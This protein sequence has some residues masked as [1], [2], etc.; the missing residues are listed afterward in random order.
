MG[1]SAPMSF[2]RIHCP[3]HFAQELLN[4]TE[5]FAKVRLN[6]YK[7][8][9]GNPTSTVVTG[10][11]PGGGTTDVLSVTTTYDARERPSSM[12][13]VLTIGGNEKARNTTTY[14]YDA[15]GRQSS[16]SSGPTSTAD[17]LESQYGY[18]LQQWMSSISTVLG[19]RT[20]FSETLGYDSPST[21][22]GGP[23]YTGLI[24]RKGE[25]W[26][27]PTSSIDSLS[28]SRTED[29]VYDYAA[30]LSTWDDS[31]NGENIS[32]DA[33]GNITLR[34]P[35]YGSGGTITQT[36][37]GDRLATRKVGTAA[38]VSF[39]HDS[40]ARMTTDAEAGLS[41]AY[42]AFNQPETI[43]SGNTLQAKYTYLSDGTKV[44]ALDASGAGLVYR[45][46]FT[47]RRSSG[48]TL[49]FESAPF[50]RGRLTE[51][52]TR[53]HVTDHLG[54][55]RAVIDGNA[56]TTTYP[57]A[58][59]YSV[60]DFAPF[61]TKSTSSA[62][63]YLSLASTGSTVSLRDG[64]TGQE[65]QGPDFGVGYSDFGARQY[66][67]SI[68]RWLVPDPMGEKY[69]DVSPYAYCAGN[70]V[71]LVDPGGL[72]IRALGINAIDTF[73]NMLSDEELQYISFDSNGVLNNDLIASYS[74]NS[75]L[76][77]TIKSLSSS[78]V[79]YDFMISDNDGEE[80]FY[81]ID[82][83]TNPG[84]Y[85]YGVTRYPGAR[86]KP[87]IDSDVHV[88]TA[89]FLDERKKAENLGHELLGHGFFYELSTKDPSI[90]PTH[91]YK[92]ISGPEE[93]D[94]ETG[95]MLSPAIRV[96]DMN[97]P[98]EKWIKQIE[99]TIRDNFDRRVNR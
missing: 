65:D 83:R 29:Y 28:V 15:L 23:S 43:S 70:P 58:G 42:N 47:Y 54:S 17:L 99:E 77:N 11:R 94:E 12:V 85:Y 45:G 13:S 31:S 7:C 95:L 97:A 41:I 57:L 14:S 69:Y 35:R 56:S 44:S 30:R 90:K 93:L 49:T 16:V 68:S 25:T 61:G 48:G 89:S 46:P 22:L 24:T 62:S 59:F 20:V 52:G 80:E 37:S 78:S 82:N 21:S 92:I 10:V 39:A 2:S 5:D 34:S 88:F 18:T 6:T 66:S 26:S 32:Y 60:N 9:A 19:D 98:I 63:S 73:L 74:G 81:D 64:F 38:A 87:S 50:D 51:V 1:K 33:R 96:S 76:L 40:F 4:K 8:L 36:Y 67:P 3:G 53:Y 79:L 71:N 84:S 91:V 72:S 55:V 27:I 75:I 86:N